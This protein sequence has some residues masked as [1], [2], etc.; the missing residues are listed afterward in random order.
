MRDS[1]RA[2]PSPL[3]S[4]RGFHSSSRSGQPPVGIVSRFRAVRGL[5]CPVR[6]SPGRK[7]SQV[8]TSKASLYA[9]KLPLASTFVLLLGK[10]DLED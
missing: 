7:M 9:Q 8:W 6:L 3:L 4:G 10:T 5:K 2:L 1:S